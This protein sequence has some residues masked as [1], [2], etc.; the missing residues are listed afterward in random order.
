MMG[1]D[2]SDQKCL[3][4][5]K[6]KRGVVKVSLTRVRTF[7]SKYNSREDAITILIFSQEE[8]SQINCKFDQFQSQIELIDVDNFEKAEQA[9]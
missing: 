4:Y 7:V 9:R 5:L 6:R 3:N 1:L 8:L 2:E